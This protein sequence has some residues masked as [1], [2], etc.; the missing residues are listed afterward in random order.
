MKLYMAKHSVLYQGQ[1]KPTNLGRLRPEQLR[2][3]PEEEGLGMKRN[4]IRASSA[5][6]KLMSFSLNWK[7]TDLIDGPLVG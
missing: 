7:D 6:S 2:S 1:N 5:C 3:D 4:A